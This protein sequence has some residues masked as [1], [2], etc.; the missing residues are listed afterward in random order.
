MVTNMLKMTRDDQM[1]DKYE[2]PI[3]A[4]VD[5][6]GRLLFNFFWHGEEFAERYGDAKMP[7]LEDALRNNFENAGDLALQLQTRGVDS[8]PEESAQSIDLGDTADE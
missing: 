4:F 2:K 3:L 6:C 1:I 8:N 7:D 5:A